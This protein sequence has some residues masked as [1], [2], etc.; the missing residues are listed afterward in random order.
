MTYYTTGQVT[1]I[2]SISKPTLYKLCKSKNINPQRTAGGNYRF[3]DYDVKKL[4]NQ[5]EDEINIEKQFINTVNDVWFILKKLAEEIWGIE[6][7]EKL[8]DILRKNQKEI[9][10]L[11][12]SNFKE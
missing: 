8:K 6:G 5:N 1:K 4:L 2:L 12:V 10:I 11:N 9:F 3:S 7:E